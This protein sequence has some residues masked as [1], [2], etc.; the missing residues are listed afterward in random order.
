VPA[1][2]QGVN[3]AA[4]FNMMSGGRYNAPQTAASATPQS[5]ADS[6]TDWADVGQTAALLKSIAE[7]ASSVPDVDLARI[8]SL[9]R[10]VQLGTVSADPQQIAESF[11]ELETLLA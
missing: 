10:A 11:M 8:A 2:I 5:L 6:G 4:P 7:T 9:Q 3:T 1:P